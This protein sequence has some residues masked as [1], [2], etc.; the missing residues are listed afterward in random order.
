MDVYIGRRMYR[1][2]ARQSA[3][4]GDK[5]KIVTEARVVSAPGSLV[6]FMR[7]LP[8]GIAAIGLE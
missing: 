1:W 5:G 4:I 7:E 8:H 6:A 3:L 2:Q